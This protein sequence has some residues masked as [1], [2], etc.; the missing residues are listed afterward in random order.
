MTDNVATA[1]QQL[2]LLQEAG[3]Y[4]RPSTL[5]VEIGGMFV[6]NIVESE[7]E[8]IGYFFQYVVDETSA[9]Q[10]ALHLAH[11]PTIHSDGAE[12]QTAASRAVFDQTPENA[13]HENYIEPDT[14][15]TIRFHDTGR[16][17]TV[18]MFFEFEPVSLTNADAPHSPIMFSVRLYWNHTCVELFPKFVYTWIDDLGLGNEYVSPMSENTHFSLCPES[19]INSHPLFK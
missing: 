15:I 19:T 9:E 18:E 14:A 1:Q 8:D 17:E 13:P 6:E 16:E 11:V 10:F 5:I 2:T 3:L 12:L 4:R 7:I